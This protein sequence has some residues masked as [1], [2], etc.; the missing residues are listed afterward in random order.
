VTDE[1]AQQELIEYL[2][3]VVPGAVVDCAGCPV[4]R[5][6]SQAIQRDGKFYCTEVCA[7]KANALYRKPQPKSVLAD[8]WEV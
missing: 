8:N 4:K 2:T 6:V 3:Q 5:P 7:D 1:K